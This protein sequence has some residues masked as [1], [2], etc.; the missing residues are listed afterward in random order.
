MFCCLSWV[1]T[2]CSYLSV[3]TLGVITVSIKGAAFHTYFVVHYSNK[4]IFLTVV[5]LFV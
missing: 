5:N 4:D 3:P 2:D 1:Y